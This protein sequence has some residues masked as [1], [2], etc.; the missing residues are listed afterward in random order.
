MMRVLPFVGF[1]GLT[2]GCF[3]AAVA[4][5][6]PSRRNELQQWGGG[7]LV[8]SVALLGLAFPFI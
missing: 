5:I 7:L 3:A 6:F 4:D 8:G 1:A 2:I